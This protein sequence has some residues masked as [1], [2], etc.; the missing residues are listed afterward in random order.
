M[1]VPRLPPPPQMTL[2]NA[3]L[4]L[5]SSAT[6][7][8]SAHC[9]EAL[10][11]RVYFGSEHGNLLAAWQEPTCTLA[12]GSFSTEAF[13]LFRV[14][15]LDAAAY[16]GP[17]AARRLARQGQYSGRDPG[18]YRLPI[19]DGTIF[20]ATADGA[21]DRRVYAAACVHRIGSRA[22]WCCRAGCERKS[23]FNRRKVANANV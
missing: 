5:D 13:C 1:R 16:E 19:L 21:A 11:G 7:R 9:A 2:R 4:P 23:T 20:M 10:P 18:R 15:A 8:R 22:V 17:P 6:P 3:R 12:T 14:T